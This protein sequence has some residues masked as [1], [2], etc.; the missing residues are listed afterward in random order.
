[1]TLLTTYKT[2]STKQIGAKLLEMTYKQHEYIGNQSDILQISLRET[3][4]T[5][6]V[7]LE[8]GVYFFRKKISS[9]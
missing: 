8:K 9:S 5:T 3:F 4:N 6:R 2:T 7:I 1:M